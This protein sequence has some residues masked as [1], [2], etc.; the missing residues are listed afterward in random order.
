MPQAETYLFIGCQADHGI[1]DGCHFAAITHDGSVIVY[2]FANPPKADLKRV[3]RDD[4]E[5]L[6][7]KGKILRT[8]PILETLL[9]DPAG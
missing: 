1:P 2:V 8:Q 5:S 7:N 3:H 9:R 6:Q 4:F